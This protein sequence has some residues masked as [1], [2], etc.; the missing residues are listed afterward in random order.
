MS[1][2]LKAAA[3]LIRERGW[4]DGH[5][6]NQG[7]TVCAQN[8]ISAVCVGKFN[9]DN[10]YVATMDELAERIRPGYSSY[11]GSYTVVTQYNDSLDDPAPLLELMERD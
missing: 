5:T 6:A 7:I 2:T 9:D 4:W 10:L 1:E 3:A 11:C 8:A